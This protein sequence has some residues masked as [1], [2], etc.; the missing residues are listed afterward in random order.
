MKGRK[1]R[2]KLKERCGA[3]IEMRSEARN[4]LGPSKGCSSAMAP[5]AVLGA[6]HSRPKPQGE[7][8]FLDTFSSTAR[9]TKIHAQQADHL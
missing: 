2:D 5:A 6:G 3:A 4:G 9:E 8:D 7:L 1:V